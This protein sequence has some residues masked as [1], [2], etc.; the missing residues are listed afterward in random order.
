MGGGRENRRTKECIVVERQGP[1]DK[2]EQK[3]RYRVVKSLG[4][5]TGG[6]ESQ[7]NMFEIQRC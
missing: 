7:K 3:K 4:P 5:T 2:E 6:E 1:G